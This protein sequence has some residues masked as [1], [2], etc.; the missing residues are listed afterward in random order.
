VRALSAPAP[1]WMDEDRES[2][3]GDNTLC[4]RLAHAMLLGSSGND[5]I[6]CTVE[7]CRMLNLPGPPLR[8]LLASVR[9][10]TDD[11]KFAMLTCAHTG[12]EPRRADQARADLGVSFVPKVIATD[13]DIDT[14]RWF[15]EELAGQRPNP[16]TRSWWRTSPAA[17]M[18]SRSPSRSGG[19]TRSPPVP[20]RPC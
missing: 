15:C 17:A 12:A 2:C 20:G 16:P 6:A 18:L 1:V 19:W 9:Q 4:S 11:M 13:P 3:R 14:F 5:V 8:E 10:Q 7:H